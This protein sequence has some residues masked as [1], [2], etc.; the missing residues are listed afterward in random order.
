MF[1][2]FIRQAT[3]VL[4]GSLVTLKQNGPFYF[5]WADLIYKERNMGKSR[6][7]C[8]NRGK[9]FKGVSKTGVG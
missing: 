8:L 9:S 6:D 1:A 4:F 5:A 7:S 2:L 3:A